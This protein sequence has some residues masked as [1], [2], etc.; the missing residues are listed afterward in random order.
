MKLC[1]R[2]LFRKLKHLLREDQFWGTRGGYTRRSAGDE[3]SQRR[4]A[5]RP[6]QEAPGHCHDVIAVGGDYVY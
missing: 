6:T 2:F 3:E 1:D 4:R 5:L